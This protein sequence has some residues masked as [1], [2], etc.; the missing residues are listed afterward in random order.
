MV[1]EFQYHGKHSLQVFELEKKI[2]SHYLNVFFDSS[3]NTQ[4]FHTPGPTYTQLTFVVSLVDN[5]FSSKYC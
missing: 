2:K 4:Y 3:S 1:K 5:E